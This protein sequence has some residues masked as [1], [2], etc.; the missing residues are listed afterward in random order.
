MIGF[1][2]DDLDRWRGPYPRDVFIAQFQKLSDGWQQA[3][4]ELRRAVELAS[5][6]HRSGAERDLRFAEAAGLHF[7]SVVNQSRFVVARDGL[8]KPGIKPEQ[9]EQ[10]EAEIRAILQDE[11][12]VAKELFSLTRQD[13][14]I[15][16]EASNQYYYLP[17]DLMEK[18]IDCRYISAS[19]QSRRGDGSM[20]TDPAQAAQ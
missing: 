3:L 4:A 5:P 16:F 8:A 18:V 12:A 20:R 11:I 6:A 13:S 1:P 15:G 14:R 19:N 10:F 17:Q 2:Y 7:R 9:R